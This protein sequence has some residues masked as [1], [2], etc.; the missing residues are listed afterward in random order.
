MISVQV[1]FTWQLSISSIHSFMSVE[2]VTSVRKSCHRSLQKY[3]IP[4]PVLQ[5]V[6]TSTS[7]VYIILWISFLSSNLTFTVYSIS[8]KASIAGTLKATKGVNAGGIFMTV[9]CSFCTFI[10]VYTKQNNGHK[11][12]SY[13]FVTIYAIGVIVSN[14]HIPV[15]L[16][17]SPAN[18]VLQLQL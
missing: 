8:R 17:P 6:T 5:C 1:A 9:V 14:V 16:N 18:P 12:F 13:T 11:C 10:D 3:R 7:K 2:K 15:Q 4:Y